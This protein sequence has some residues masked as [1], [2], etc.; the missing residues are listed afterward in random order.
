MTETFNGKI[1][2]AYRLAKE[3]DGLEAEKARIEAS[4]KEA[5]S[6]L[7]DAK[8]FLLSE[9][10]ASSVDEAK[11]GDVYVNLFHRESIAYEDPN[12]VLEYLEDTG[13]TDLIR[14]KRELDKKAINKAVKTDGNL[15]NALASMTSKK[16]TS[17]V[18]VTDDNNHGK[19]LEHLAS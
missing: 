3:I 17:Y 6:K 8:K 2:E 11:E 14:V 13:R 19:M 18:V 12:K 9:M 16:V 1:I 5:T 7:E 4:L 10:Q 15:A